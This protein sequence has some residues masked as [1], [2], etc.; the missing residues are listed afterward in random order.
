MHLAS[1]KHVKKAMNFQLLQPQHQP[2]P[3]M[4]TNELP[5]NVPSS[6]GVS[7]SFG[8][9]A[10][11]DSISDNSNNADARKRKLDVNNNVTNIL[12]FN[13][14]N[15]NAAFGITVDDL[16]KKHKVIASDGIMNEGQSLRCEICN[17]VFNGPDPFQVRMTPGWNCP[18]LPDNR[19][20]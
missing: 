17:K 1:Q 7:S 19:I 18:H 10:L 6:I 20:T 13:N 3:T 12:S 16:A 9:N 8:G 5:S 2:Q 4:S 15:N 14:N 11:Y